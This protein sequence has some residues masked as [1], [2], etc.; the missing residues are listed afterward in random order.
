MYNIYN[1]KKMK[2][3][4]PPA[5]H[6]PNFH[7]HNL[8]VNKHLLVCGKT[9][10]GKTNW[11]LNYIRVMQDVFS[12]I[13]IF[14]KDADEPAYNL[15]NSQLKDRVT[16]RGLNEI[17]NVKDLEQYGGENLVVFDDFITEGKK[18]L[19]VLKQYAIIGRKKHCTCCYLTQ[20]Y[21]AVD[22]K[23][24]QQCSYLVLLNS[25]NQ[26][27]LNLIATTLSSPVSK[28][29]IKKIIGNATK[30]SLNV[31]LIDI[32]NPDFNKVFRRN[33]YDY[34]EII[35]ENGDELTRIKMYIGSG[36]LN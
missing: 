10:S 26:Q 15:L 20:A 31:C 30:E 7:Q 8:A 13:H 21:Y 1:T 28:D 19:E 33:F 6:N 2:A 22:N 34:Y 17:P 35:D 18:I 14:T 3:H 11:L 4:L 9:G 24:R 25:T 23:L 29:T 16:I 36:I 5:P 27:N 32:C 12:H